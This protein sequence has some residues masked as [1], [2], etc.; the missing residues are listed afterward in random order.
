[1]YQTFEDML[2]EYLTELVEFPYAAWHNS[3]Q[4]QEAQLRRRQT[5]KSILE[6]IPPKQQQEAD[7]LLD[8]LDCDR[9]AESIFYYQYGIKDGIRILKLLGVL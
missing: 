7:T 5:E 3:P 4:Y 9:S 8:V 1:M 2:Q 6:L